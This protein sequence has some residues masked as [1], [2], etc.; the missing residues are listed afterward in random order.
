MHGS[1]PTLAVRVTPA[2]ILDGRFQLEAEHRRGGMG[3][4]WKARDLATQRRVAVKI[5]HGRSAADQAQ[6]GGPIAFGRS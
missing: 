4:I 3:A 5:L 1:S 2:T 6:R